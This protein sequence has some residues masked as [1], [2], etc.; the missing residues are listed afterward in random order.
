MGA[1]AAEAECAGINGNLTIALV[2]NGVLCEKLFKTIMIWIA[3]KIGGSEDK[4]QLEFEKFYSKI[5]K[6]IIILPLAEVR[7]MESNPKFSLTYAN[8]FS[9]QEKKSKSCF[10]S[11]QL[12]SNK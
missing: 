11:F 1:N 5:V 8:Y 10:G 2:Y 9:T 7:E 4:Q 3:E 6:K 12:S